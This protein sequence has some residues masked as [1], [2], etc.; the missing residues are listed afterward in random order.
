MIWVA[1]RQ[2]R[3]QAAVMLAGLAVVATVVLITGLQLRQLYDT[4]GIRGCKAAGDC[5]L[6][7]AAFTAHYGWLQ[8]LLGSVLLQFL[9]AVVGVFWGAP[10]IAREFE[11]G[12]FRLAW[13]QSVTR[14]RWLAARIAVVGTASV[15][16]VG[17]L[18]WLVTWWFTPIDNLSHDKFDPSIFSQRD[19]APLGY[20]ALAFAFG[21]TAGLL[22]RHTLPA[23]ASTLAGYIAARIAVLAWVRPNFAAPVQFT[24]PLPSQTLPPVTGLPPGAAV[25]MRLNGTSAPTGSWLVSSHITNAAGHV[26][27]ALQLPADAPCFT[28]HNCLAGFHQMIAYQPPSRYWPFQWAEAGMFVGVAALLIGF[29]FWWINGRRRPRT[30]R[31]ARL[32][33]GPDQPSHLRPQLSATAP[34]P[35]TARLSRD[36]AS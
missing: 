13:T 19:I 17:L 34:Q 20:A 1:W 21:L 15:A 26:V 22:I 32:T 12:T 8:T 6:V 4:S 25:S 35:P 14:T 18:S 7:T 23:M 5:D 16:A 31:G 30:V 28:T 33:T 3:T 9:P 27:G 11:T 10:L 36:E 29:C 24:T 2:F